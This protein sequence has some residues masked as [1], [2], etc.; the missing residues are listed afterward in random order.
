MSWN[1]RF[2]K[3][4]LATAALLAAVLG[5]SGCTR[6][7]VASHWFGVFR[8]GPPV[9]GRPAHPPRESLPPDQSLR[10]V[11][12]QQAEGAFNPATDDRRVQLLSTRLR[13]DPQDVAARLELAAIF[14]RYRLYEDA[15][16]HYNRALNL[17]PSSAAAAG[18]ARAARAAGRGSEVLPLLTAFLKN[19]PEE[20]AEVWNELGIIHDQAGDRA[21]AERAFR[22]AIAQNPGS[23]RLHNNLGYNLLLQNLLEGAEAA[24]RHALQL[25]PASIAARNNL[26]ITL[27]RRGDIDGARREFLAA[28]GAAAAHNNL[29]VVLMEM[30]DYEQ[31]RAELVGALQARNYFAPAIENFKLVQEL[32]RQRADLP[33]AAGSL[34]LSI[35]R[36]PKLGPILAGKIGMKSEEPENHP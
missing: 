24:F 27:A 32:L 33:T 13:L 15:L 29:A 12:A 36:V 2:V 14:E 16:D 35:V 19:S 17:A 30:G 20:T 3:V 28:G 4:S 8:P 9:R 11:F 22:Q 21:A 31:S 34:P 25:N 6:R 5:W 26:G 23:D 1:S 18:L 7:V 10:Q